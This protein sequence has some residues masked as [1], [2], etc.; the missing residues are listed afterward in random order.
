MGN[1]IN[2]KSNRTG[3]NFAG[4]AYT[5][6]VYGRRNKKGGTYKESSPAVYN[7]HTVAGSGYCIEFF[8]SENNAYCAAALRRDRD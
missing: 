3:G 4:R 7:K 1:R 2:I 8:H 5:D 6:T